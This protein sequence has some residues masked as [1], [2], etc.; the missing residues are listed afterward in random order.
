MRTARGRG[1]LAEDCVG[2][3]WSASTVDGYAILVHQVGHELV[4]TGA[5]NER[6]KAC[7]A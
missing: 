4:R 7:D 3:H 2:F 6:S 1:T 5:G